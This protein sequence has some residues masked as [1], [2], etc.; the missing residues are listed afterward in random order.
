[1]KAATL[2]TPRPIGERPLSVDTAD[3]PEAPP[4]HVLVRVHACG[5][6]RTD[7]HIVEG[8]LPPKRNRLIP[9]HQ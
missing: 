4:G 5:V 8:E 7:L 2:S 3:T 9:G 1:M 6:C